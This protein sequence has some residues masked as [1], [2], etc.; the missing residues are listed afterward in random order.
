MNRT[1]ETSINA[2]SYLMLCERKI[3]NV[4]EEISLQNDS[5]DNEAKS[6]FST[7]LIEKL[8]MYT[9]WDENIQK[10]V[11]EDSAN[12]VNK[13]EL[14]FCEENLIYVLETIK[15]RVF[16]EFHDSVTTKH[17]ERNKTLISLK[18]W[19]YW[20]KMTN[21]VKKYVR[22]CDTCIRTKLSKHFVHEELMSLSTSNKVWL[23]V[24]ID[25]IIDLSKSS[26]YK[27]K[28]IHDT[29]II[30]VNKLTKIT[31]YAT[32]SKDMNSKKF[33]ELVLKIL[34]RIIKCRRDF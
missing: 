34:Y 9:A 16:E 19:F 13:D 22:T 24:T 20:S 30:S 26:A 23:N 14:I 17:F 6:R 29:I 31:H 33:A 5:T 18:R 10:I 28:N 1:R 11:K 21:F 3:D 25:F 12:F 2:C 8:K 4:K 7:N 27:S 15:L 32:C